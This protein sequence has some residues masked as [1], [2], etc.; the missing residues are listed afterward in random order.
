LAA[1]T[2]GL[3]VGAVIAT[4]YAIGGGVEWGGR[5][6]AI[7]LPLVAPMIVVTLRRFDSRLLNG[8]LAASMVAL[9]VFGVGTLRHTRSATSVVVAGVRSAAND[10]DGPPV[11]LST[12]RLLPQLDWRGFDTIRWVTPMPDDLSAA[13]RQ[14]AAADIRQVVLVAD[15]PQAQLIDLPDY[16]LAAHQPQPNRIIP[17]VVLERRT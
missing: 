12:S 5:Y 14:L 4:Q 3:I 15:D 6:F 13:G 17:I 2:A 11:V 1:V 9:G 8:A 10:L 7:V 16:Q